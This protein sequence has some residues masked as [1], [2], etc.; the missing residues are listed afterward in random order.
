[1][2]MNAQIEAKTLPATRSERV[3]GKAAPISGSQAWARQLIKLRDMQSKHAGRGLLSRLL[4]DR[5][6]ERARV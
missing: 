6:K 3:G 5:A 1:M 2:S 4:A